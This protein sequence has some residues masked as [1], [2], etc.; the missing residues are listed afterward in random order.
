MTTSWHTRCGIAV[1]CLFFGAWTSAATLDDWRTRVV[2]QVLTDRFSRTKGSKHGK[3]NVV[4][5]QYCGG[6]WR[7]ISERLDY[8]EGMGFDAIWISPI[9]AQLTASTGN[10][11]SYTG[12]WGQDLYALN[13]SFGTEDDLK[14][15]VENVH[16]RG[17]YIMLDVVVNHM[18]MSILSA[19]H[20]MLMSL[21]HTQVPVR[22]LTTAC[23][24]LSTIASTSMT[25]AVLTEVTIRRT[26]KDVGWAMTSWLL[27]TF[28][29]RT[30][31]FVIC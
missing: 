29:P 17:M 19:I 15:L 1:F 18:G 24:T 23:S 5:G 13:P 31:W 11:E 10:G 2:Y 7:G 21:Q 27:P 22:T 12:Y 14:E 8:I 30:N 25:S 28:A 6:S 16:A 9:V 20:H 26:S 4:D 3:C